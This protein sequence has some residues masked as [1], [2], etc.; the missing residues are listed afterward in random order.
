IRERLRD[1]NP[2]WR[3]AATGQDSLAWTETDQALR[4]RAAYDL[5][6][7][8]GLLDD[9]ASGRVDDKLVVVRGARRVGKSVLLK[10]TAA[11]LCGRVD[12]DPRQLIYLPTDGMSAGD[13][14]RVAKLGRELTRSV[15]GLQRIWLLDEVTGIRGWTETMKYLRDN[16]EVAMDTV[17]CTGSSW[18]ETSEVERDLFTGR[19]GSHSTKRSRILHPMS[20][21]DVVAAT[22]RAIPLPEAVAPWA[23]QD[24]TAREAIGGLELFVDELDFAWQAFLTSGGFPRAVA[25]HRHQGE[26]SSAFIE[27]LASWLHRDVDPDAPADSVPR[28]LSELER[29]QTSPL[30]RNR[31]AQDLGYT[32]R[33]TFDL[34]LT[35]LVRTFAALWC[36]QV[37]EV[38]ERTA[39]AQSKLYLTDPLLG[40]IGHRL[41]S[42]LPAP[43]FTRL[44]EAAIAVAMARALD[45]HEPGRWIADDSVGYLRTG[46]GN[47]ID[48]APMPVTGPGGTMTTVPIESK[49]VASG[50]RSEAKTLEGKFSAGVVA[51]RSII[52]FE[53]P[54]WAIP[55]PALALVLE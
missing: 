15:G 37:D 52:D 42:G 24:S 48:L 1:S 14:N 16:T 33:R 40:W 26:V 35:R 5:G 10:D 22:G 39:G 27:D 32:N 53:H 17:V 8:S 47:E 11:A 30:S 4:S 18:D 38:G 13:L 31:T 43:D 29:R 12:V 45:A 9:V 49:W 44:T 51:T 54:S 25:E 41:R 23:L 2:W 46:H 20:F 50:W 19:A 6:Y 3:S 34:R 7:R 55:A 36:H 21:R 28:L